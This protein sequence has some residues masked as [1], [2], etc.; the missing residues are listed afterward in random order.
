M[1]TEDLCPGTRDFKCAREGLEAFEEFGP[2]DVI[3]FV[4]CGGCP[5][6]KAASR[7][8]LLVDKGAEVIFLASCIKIGVPVGMPCPF[9]K[10]LS[11]VVRK[12]IGDIPLVDWTHRPKS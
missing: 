1:Q 10:G 6:K 2:V 9:F 5:G 8:K 3:G 4:T 11:D 7:A 12:K